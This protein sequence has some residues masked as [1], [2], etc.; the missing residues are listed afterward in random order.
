MM[1]T[2]KRALCLLVCALMLVALLP[3]LRLPAAAVEKNTPAVLA[4]GKCGD[5]VTW[6]LSDDGTLTVKGSGA[7]ERYVYPEGGGAPD[8]PWYE[9][10]LL[11]TK[12][13]IEDGVT[14]IG[15]CA[16]AECRNLAD[17]EIPGSVTMIGADAFYRCSALTQ[18][19]IP[20]GV[21]KIR[22]NAFDSCT[23]LRSVT[24]PKGIA[25]IEY[26]AFDDCNSLKDITFLGS[27][28]KFYGSCFTGVTATV[29][30]PCNDSSW[31]DALL[32]NYGGQLMWT[33]HLF[34]D[35]EI[36]QAATCTEN[37]I[38]TGTCPV[39]G[40]TESVEVPGSAIGHSFGKDGLC[41]NCGEATTIAINMTS[42][43][44][45][46]GGWYGAE[47][48]VYADGEYLL[49]AGLGE[50]SWNYCQTVDYTPCKTYSFQWMKGSEDYVCL[51]E[52]S[53]GGKMLAIAG[54]NGMVNEE[55]L[56]T[57]DTHA[58]VDGV[59]TQCSAS[60]FPCGGSCGTDVQWE[61][62]ASG[63]LTV[64][65]T[66]PMAN[67][68][69]PEEGSDPNTP[70][71]QY[72]QM[73]TKV[74]IESGVTT[75]GE[76]AF[77]GCTNM[78]EVTIPG[79]VTAIGKLA[80]YNCNRLTGVTIP[81]GVTTIGNAAFRRC[82]GLT[83]IIIPQGVTTLGKIAFYDCTGLKSVTIPGSL[84]TIGEY[85]FGNCTGLVRVT[86]PEGVT[87]I[88]SYAFCGCSNLLNVKLPNSL[89]N[90][91]SYAFKDCTTLVDIVLPTGVKFMGD[92]AFD[93]C[94]RLNT[95]V[96]LGNYPTISNTCFNGVRCY[97]TFRRCND[98]TW[99]GKS[100]NFGGYLTWYWSVYTFNSSSEVWR[101]ATCTQNAMMVGTCMDCGGGGGTVPVPGTA[102]GHRYAEDG[103]CENCQVNFV[104]TVETNQAYSRSQ[105][106][107]KYL[108][109]Y[110]DGVLLEKVDYYDIRSNKKAEFEYP[111]CR[112]YTVKWN[113][114]TESANDWYFGFGISINGTRVVAADGDD[115]PDGTILYTLESEIDHL[116]QEI[117]T[118]PTCTKDGSVARTCSRCRSKEVLEIL[119]ATGHSYYEAEVTPPTCTESGSATNVCA[120]CGHSSITSIPATDHSIQISVVAPNCTE[121]GYRLH[122]CEN[123]DYSFRD[124]VVPAWGHSLL[125]TESAPSCTE[126]GHNLNQC[127]NC[128]YYFFDNFTPATGHRYENGICTAC[129]DVEV[130]VG[131]GDIT[132]DGKLNIM[133]VVKLYAHVKGVST[134]TDEAA[135]QLADYTGDGR[136]N[137]MD[138]AKLYTAVK[139]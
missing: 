42:R 66:G 107:G 63:V 62:D 86:I 85:A 36:E 26:D 31:T 73:I 60:V 110:G 83:G 95:I 29:F 131:P 58:Y 126:G 115:H 48:K 123:C 47:V 130:T 15:E 5:R 61:L 35:C 116:Y 2:G 109:I 122:A 136:V 13:V 134:I 97:W 118:Q 32:K 101:E 133:D 111:L 57:L 112:T 33:G 119:P 28:P 18:V 44:V 98:K 46:T 17:V 27:A 129:G 81:V 88:G 71:A 103:L 54:G 80:F 75:L 6:S 70:W 121:D 82:S 21:S 84:A 3:Q 56:L 100:T 96:F 53:V 79:S 23:G 105:W 55:T 9:H 137:I 43:N 38:G 10:R 30:Y 92:Y 14:D 94:K 68:T 37:A 51:A 114:K 24:F 64:S 74:V 127:L 135:L 1:K 90:I 77:H 45:Y 39:C 113:R 50:Y 138:I 120:D 76:Y 40:T 128:S 104:L 69:L 93:Q 8:T 89:A 16:F 124:N 34:G 78:T 49:S 99:E 52:I 4:S 108:E 11:I 67:Y 72:R 102:T 7:M 139:G 117:T 91:N 125:I 106:D 20:E 132:G 19:T 65:G 25:E 87:T 22:G 59:C 41:V 12:A